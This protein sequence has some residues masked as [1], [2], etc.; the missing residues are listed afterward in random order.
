MRRG[1]GWLALHPD[2]DLIVRRYL[3]KQARLYLPALAT[4]DEAQPAA[5]QEAGS[6][7]PGREE[8]PLERPSPPRPAARPRGGRSSTRAAPGGWSTSAAA[9]ASCSSAC[10]ADPQFAEIVG[11]DVDS[12]SPL[13]S[14]AS[15]SISIALP[16]RQR[17][18]IQLLH[19]SLLYRDRR[20]AGY[21]AAALVEVVEH[22]DPPRLAAFERGLRIRRAR[23]GGGHHAEPRVQRALAVVSPPDASATATTAS[24]GPAGVPG[25]GGGR[26]GAL[27]LRRAIPAG[28]GGG[29]RGRA[30]VA[31]GGARVVEDC[32]TFPIRAWSS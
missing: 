8:R 27:R 20:L 28:G 29:P 32:L 21:D 1:E 10:L 17:E 16:P 6:D 3:R 23:D 24:S 19:G 25:L 13:R 4:L 5:E 9:T 15:G 30:A 12:R 22:L 31:D 11:M 18:R 26:R 14:P 2:R 7:E